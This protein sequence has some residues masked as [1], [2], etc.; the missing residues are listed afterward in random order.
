MSSP[1][2][3]LKLTEKVRGGSWGDDD[4]VALLNDRVVGRIF[5]NPIHY[6]DVPWMWTIT[7]VMP[8]H[9]MTNSNGHSVDR[10]AAM[11]AFRLRWDQAGMDGR[12][13]T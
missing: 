10:D 13:R 9:T 6:P 7:V 5:H 2:L 4:F 11:K 8:D 12:L 1:T 3:I